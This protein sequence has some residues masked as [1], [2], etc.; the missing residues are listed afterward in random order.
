MTP[1]FSNGSSR[2]ILPW[3]CF[4]Q[5]FTSDHRPASPSPAPAPPRRRRRPRPSA[6]AFLAA[7]PEPDGSWDG[8]TL[9]DRSS[10]QGTRLAICPPPP[11]PPP[12]VGPRRGESRRKP[13]Q[14]CASGRS[15]EP[16]TSSSKS[17]PFAPRL[18]SVPAPVQT[19]RTGFIS[20]S[21]KPVGALS[22]H[23]KGQATT[24]SPGPDSADAYSP[25]GSE[26]KK[27]TQTTPQPSCSSGGPGGRIAS[28]SSGGPAVVQGDAS[29]PA[30]AVVQ[31]DASHLVSAEEDARALV[32]PIH[33][34]PGQKSTPPGSSS[35]ADAPGSSSEAD[36][37]GTEVDASE[38]GSQVDVASSE[39]VGSSDD[40]ASHPEVGSSDDVACGLT[41][42]PSPVPVVILKVAPVQPA[43][44]LSPVQPVSP[45]QPAGLLC[46]R[47]WP[48]RDRPRLL[49]CPRRRPPRGSSSSPHLLQAPDS[50]GP[51]PPH[52][53]QALTSKG[54]SPPHLQ[55]AQAS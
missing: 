33:G 42:P 18:Q 37:P 28:C 20:F 3:S 21:P 7:L 41:S 34:A 38:V 53:Q 17:P 32:Q 40:V 35:E 14:P 36:A 30:P 22:A 15:F 29:P 27:P 16:A 5:W 26:P 8:E 11:P 47:R 48:P 9:L 39:V 51:S 25:V 43:G 1:P 6:S 10:Y 52:L 49:I 50:K 12:G 2:E 13:P 4:L 23:P 24:P 45:A 54:P 46:R 31:G 19:I 55:Q 44:T